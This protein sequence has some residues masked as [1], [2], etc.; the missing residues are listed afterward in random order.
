MELN[1][2]ASPLAALVWVRA[3][4]VVPSTAAARCGPLGLGCVVGAVPKMHWPAADRAAETAAT[5]SGLARMLA[6]RNVV[7]VWSPTSALEDARA[8]TCNTPSSGCRSS[9]LCH[10]LSSSTTTPV[11]RRRAIPTCPLGLDGVLSFDEPDDAAA[12]EH[13]MDGND[14]VENSHRLRR[15]GT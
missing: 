7:E 13:Y 6:R 5:P 3:T 12:Y 10:A 15:R 11:G 1:I 2:R 14:S 4:M 8:T 9:L